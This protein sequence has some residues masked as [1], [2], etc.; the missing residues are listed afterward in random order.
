M[1]RRLTSIEVCRDPWRGKR[2]TS[3][4]FGPGG[5]GTGG[6]AWKVV[7]VQRVR[8]WTSSSGSREARHDDDTARALR[9]MVATRAQSREQG[10]LYSVPPINV[11]ST[12]PPDPMRDYVAFVASQFVRS[13][14]PAPPSAPMDGSLCS[15]RVCAIV[16]WARQ[17]HA[18]ASMVRRRTGMPSS[19]HL[20]SPCVHEDLAKLLSVGDHLCKVIVHHRHHAALQRAVEALHEIAV[21]R[22][23]CSQWASSSV[24][25]LLRWEA[26]NMEQSARMVVY[27]DLDVEI[28]PRWPA[29]LTTLGL[30]QAPRRRDDESIK[31][32]GHEWHQLIACA[33]RSRY[34]LL[35][36]PDHSSPVHGGL[37]ILR[38]NVTLFREGLAL[39]RR[40]AAQGGFNSSAGWDNLGPPRDVVPASDHVWHR[41]HGHSRIVDAND[42]AFVGG[43]VD[44]GFIFHMLRVRHRLGADIRITECASP[45]PRVL[46][47]NSAKPT[48]NLFHFGA[49]GGA[50]PDETLRRWHWLDSHQL[51]TRAKLKG[52]FAENH[53]VLT[54]SLAW[55]A[56]TAAEIDHL[57]GTAQQERVDGNGIPHALY[58]RSQ[59]NSCS[60]A[61]NVGVGCLSRY[62]RTH[63]LEAVRVPQHTK[64]SHGNYQPAFGWCDRCPQREVLLSELLT[65]WSRLLP[66]SIAQRTSTDHDVDNRPSSSTAPM[67]NVSD[68]IDALSV[69]TRPIPLLA[70]AEAIR[71]S[72]YV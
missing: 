16:A 14:P 50:K 48:A 8:R 68:V 4:S 21:N 40:T 49:V 37:L 38:P 11:T 2:T 28:L 71:S 72:Y 36:Y 47:S 18:V 25:M 45:H 39:L 66:R 41:Q 5:G 56:M 57:L 30:S 7:A 54:R 19:V 34:S 58:A 69:P 27:L 70:P 15:T 67:R 61:I 52:Y 26:M 3:F 51:C 33:L 35:S 64:P 29:L 24:F 42:W 62:S 1:M 17:V 22:R 53:E 6:G 55:M 32:V 31:R 23:C 12:P 20:F 10:E 13:V 60:A 63:H 46:S 44:Q 65:E 59:L 43:E 9:S